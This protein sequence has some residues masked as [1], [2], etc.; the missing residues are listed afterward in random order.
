[1]PVD[2][3]AEEAGRVQ[4]AL[5]G[6][7]TEHDEDG[8]AVTGAVDL[9]EQRLESEPPVPRRKQPERVGGTDGE[10]DP[11]VAVQPEVADP[12]SGSLGRDAPAP[13]DIHHCPSTRPNGEGASEL[14]RQRQSE[15]RHAEPDRRAVPHD[16]HVIGVRADSPL[17]RLVDRMRKR[18]E[19]SLHP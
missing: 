17:A 14:A 8:R 3:I 18:V 10:H 9:V 5:H 6:W 15:R 19:L 16:Q 7:N 1:M 11:V 4:R 13:R 2:E 12:A